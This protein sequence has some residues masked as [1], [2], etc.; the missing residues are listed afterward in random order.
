MLIIF[1]NK[2]EEFQ[3]KLD[4]KFKEENQDE[5]ITSSKKVNILADVQ[6]ILDDAGAVKFALN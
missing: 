2:I 1:L 6:L 5:E 3:L 4:T